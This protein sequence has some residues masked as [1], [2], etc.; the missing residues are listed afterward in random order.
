[1]LQLQRFTI[2]QIKRNLNLYIISCLTKWFG[3]LVHKKTNGPLSNGHIY[4]WSH[5]LL[6]HV[7]GEAI[8]RKLKIMLQKGLF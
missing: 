5:L 8:K 7:M 2:D 3:S 4:K 1:M 6:V